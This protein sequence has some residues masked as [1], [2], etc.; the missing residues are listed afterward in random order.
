MSDFQAVDVSDTGRA[1]AR[2]PDAKRA[3]ALRARLQ[4]VR[5]EM[6]RLESAAARY[7]KLSARCRQLLH[8][9]AEA[10]NG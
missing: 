9:I 8:Q 2:R 5:V 3:S 1:P 7:D 6:R 10:E 4:S